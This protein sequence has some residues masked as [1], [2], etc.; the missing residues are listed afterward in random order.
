MKVKFLIILLLLTCLLGADVL[1][2]DDFN[3]EDGAVGNGWNNVG[4]SVNSVIESSVMK[5]E[6]GFNRGIS[7]SFDEIN[8]NVIYIQY[9][10]KF[11]TSDWFVSSF[12]SDVPVYLLW[13]NTGSIYTDAS[14]FYSNPSLLGNYNVNTWVSVKWMINLDNNHYS[15]W[16]ND[17]LLVEEATNNNIN[18]FT[19]FNFRTSNGSFGTQF[20]DNF[21]IYDDTAPETPTGL[22]LNASPT[23]I[24]LQWDQVSN[25]DFLIYEIYRSTTSPALDFL[26]QVS[27]E[28]NEFIDTSAQANTDYFYRIKAIAMNSL[29]SGFSEEIA[30][31]LLPHPNFTIET[32]VINIGQANPTPTI[33]MTIENTGAYQLNF[34]LSGVDD[35]L[36][37]DQMVGIN[38]FTPVGIFQGHSYYMSNERM[39]W[40]DAKALCEEEGGHLI[41]ITSQEENDFIADNISESSWIGLTDELLEGQ[42]Q[43]V[44]GEIFEYDNW[45]P[46]EP[47][48]SGSGEDYVHLGH[49][50]PIEQWNDRSNSS[51][52]NSDNPY[53][54]LE[55]DFLF[56]LS[57]LLFDDNSGTIPAGQS[58]DFSIF[59]QASHL[60]DGL[61]ES[62]IKLNVAGISEAFYY[63]ISI[64]VDF[65]PPSQIQDFRVDATRTD[66][67]QIGLTWTAHSSQDQVI[68]YFIFRKGRYESDWTEMGQVDGNQ[69]YFIDNNFTPLDTTYVYYALQAEDWV[70]NQSQM[71]EPVIAS[72]ERYR[73]PENLQI[74]NLNNRDIQLTWTPVTQTIAGIS[75]TPSCYI[76]YK[77]QYPSPLSD[78]DFLAISE[79]P[80]FIH[81]WALYFQPANRLY[82]IVTA[83]GGE[84]GRINRILSEKGVWTK[85]E[86][87]QRLNK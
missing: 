50:L 54:L 43:W 23:D 64:N 20:V 83:Y 63:P 41:T 80:E 52:N 2:Y 19:S 34:N 12:P 30:G 11:S 59:I 47:N 61:Y 31:H 22:S 65:N 57:I 70:G 60:E 77:S 72:L 17:N 18:D 21:L 15:I 85:S 10:W 14:G 48:N 81:N 42:W 71:S 25:N 62:A 3:R 36:D 13:E 69:N 32:D 86:L 68:T 7:K 37:E 58:Q 40:F 74:T 24:I 35:L 26:D 8:T 87:D 44:T 67:N 51:A 56:P 53:A 6:A 78:Y 66:A 82:Y 79:S 39:S 55:F 73:A 76:I 4:P 27:G 33:A 38:G 75:G 45:L 29:E 49:T 16:I 1:F 9:D 84:L 28:Y 5:V 46:G